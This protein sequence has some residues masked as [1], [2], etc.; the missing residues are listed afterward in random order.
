MPERLLNTGFFKVLYNKNKKLCLK[1]SPP[2]LKDLPQQV[3]YYQRYCEEQHQGYCCLES[4]PAFLR[5]HFH[6][7]YAAFLKCQLVVVNCPSR[8]G[9]PSGFR[10]REKYRKLPDLSRKHYY[11]IRINHFYNLAIHLYVPFEFCID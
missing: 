10:R 6:I 8:K 1:P 2:L 9:I 5:R 11:F 7:E 4:A 3:K